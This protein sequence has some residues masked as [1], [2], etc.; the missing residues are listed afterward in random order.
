VIDS[1]RAELIAIQQWP[2]DD[3][4]TETE[5]IAVLFREIRSREIKDKIAEIASTN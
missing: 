4:R 2:S 3:L 5:I 1:L